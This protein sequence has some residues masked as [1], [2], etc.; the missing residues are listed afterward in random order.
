MRADKTEIEKRKKG[1]RQTLFPFLR[2]RRPNEEKKH[3]ISFA[4]ID[5][6]CFHK[7]RSINIRQIPNPKKETPLFSGGGGGYN[8]A[9]QKEEGKKNKASHL[10][11]LSLYG[12]SSIKK[13][14]FFSL[15]FTG[16]LC[17]QG[18]RLFSQANSLSLLLLAPLEQSNEPSSSLLFPQGEGGGVP[19]LFFLSLSL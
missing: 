14:G 4:E 11:S 1:K 8:M 16:I 19:F 7:K 10:T 12:R 17:T 18:F 13:W 3:T 5:N 2:K 9:P 15:F 6:C